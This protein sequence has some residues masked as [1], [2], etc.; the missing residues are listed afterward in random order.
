MTEQEI[1]NRL[2]EKMLRKRIVGAKNRQV[3]TVVDMALPS[4]DQGAGKRAIDEMLADT[5][6][7]IER[8]GG[9]RG[10]IPLTSV[11]DAVAYLERHGGNVPFGFG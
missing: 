1:R 4:H 7:P 9:Q 6:A 8:Y 3:A 2:V 11:E 5:S 10:T